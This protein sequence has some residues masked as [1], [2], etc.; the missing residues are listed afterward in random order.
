MKKK[1]CILLVVILVALFA[2]GKWLD[3]HTKDANVAGSGVSLSDELNIDG[4]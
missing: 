3:E 1:L 2:E 4:D